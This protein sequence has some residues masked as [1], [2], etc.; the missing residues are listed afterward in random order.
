MK[1]LDRLKTIY[2]IAASLLAA[3][4]L[5]ACAPSEAKQ[6][7]LDGQQLLVEKNY[8]EAEALFTE[9]V[10][11][12][13]YLAEAYRGLGIA[14]V[15]QAE[16]A[17]ASISFSKAKLAVDTQSDAFVRD[18]D[19]YLAYCRMKQ[20]RVDEAKEMYDTLLA[21]EKDAE[22][23]YLRGR[24][25]MS[26]GD[27]EKAGADFEEAV[28]L[29]N[30]YNLYIS[31]YELY[32]EYKM[33]ADGAAFLEMA[34][35][36]AERTESD[37]YGRGVIQYYLQNYDEAKEEL[38]ADLRSDRN[39]ERAVLLLGKTYLA[40]DDAANARAM[41]REYLENPECAAAAYNGLAMCDLQERNYKSALDNIKA[42]LAANDDTIMESLLYNEIIVYEHMED[43]TTAKIKAAAFAATYPTNEAG[44]RENEFL[45]TR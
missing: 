7:I 12:E 27:Y 44:Q 21:E 15:F 35:D 4:M 31:I 3:V 13:R 28:S 24:I 14:Q 18:I 11:E 8:E 17:E 19:K 25:Y 32:G 26:E 43:W 6:R 16:Y 37:H 1:K 36:M 23:L 45:K 39:D 29:S 5:T 41:Y 40:M 22:L 20:G 10:E 34:M 2:M 9:A 33:D 30:D 38:I 42:G